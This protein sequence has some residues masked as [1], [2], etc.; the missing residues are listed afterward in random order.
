MQ[1][2]IRWM[3]N[4]W[5]LSFFFRIFITSLRISGGALASPVDPRGGTVDRA[6]PVSAPAKTIVK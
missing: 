6:P 1:Y 4:N 5:K 3:L 2:I